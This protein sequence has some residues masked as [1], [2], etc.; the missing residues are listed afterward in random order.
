[1][2]QSRFTPIGSGVALRRREAETRVGLIHIPEAHAQAPLWFDVAYV[3]P[4]VTL[5]RPG[6]AAYVARY[7]GQRVTLDGVDHIIVQEDEIL[8]IDERDG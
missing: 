2:P 6:D 7:T 3:G 1:M 5:V 4:A 8:G